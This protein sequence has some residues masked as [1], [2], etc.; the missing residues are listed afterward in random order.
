MPPKTLSL[1]PG[2]PP[3][4]AG[5]YKIV[6][7]L[8]N[9]GIAHVYLAC[10]ET[11]KRWVSIKV[12]STKWVSDKRV[13]GRFKNEAET[14]RRVEHHSVVKVFDVDHDDPFTPFTVME[15]A[16][17]GNVEAWIAEHG[18]ME[19]YLAI[20]VMAM[21]CSA[22]DKAHL[23][24]VEHAELGA[25]HL[26][27][28]RHGA[29]KLAGFRGTSSFGGQVE[30]FNDTADAAEI[31]YFLLTAK[32]FEVK[33]KRQLVQDLNPILAPIVD[34]GTRRKKRGNLFAGV[35]ALSRELE[36]S[37]LKLP[38]PPHPVA[39]LATRDCWLPDDW[40]EVFDPELQFPDLEIAKRMAD[41]PAFVPETSEMNVYAQITR[42]QSDSVAGTTES[43]GD[44]VSDNLMF[45][46]VE[47]P[48]YQEERAKTD[49]EDWVRLKADVAEDADEVRWQAQQEAKRK[50]IDAG[51]MISNFAL[52]RLLGIA[53]VGGFLVIVVTIT[54]GAFDV[55][56]ARKRTDAAGVTLI[57]VVEGEGNVVY[58]LSAAGGDRSELEKL[59]FEYKDAP[60]R[61]KLDPAHE[62]ASFVVSEAR[63]NGLDPMAFGGPVD[64]TTRSISEVDNALRFYDAN[65][66]NWGDTAGR[67]PGNLAAFVGIARRP[68]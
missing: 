33:R 37:I 20:H 26:L 64:E 54:I 24:G 12:L 31:L 2:Q 5:R 52:F 4:L 57:K 46:K 43:T 44:Y 66:S 32:R 47:G 15:A 28:D 39:A 30:A 61:Q 48:L 50:K 45:Q 49:E 36:A 29:I 62:F 25:D 38:V 63:R 11:E 35:M 13:R 21:L 65:Q 6:A 8:D 18:N 10:D 59:Y 22:L 68:K 3:T 19:P 51:R 27:I 17:G 16:E 7:T 53:V 23:S 56:S 67:F 40:T 60:G 41:D 34:K 9:A 42:L 14:L 55:R 1:E 58:S